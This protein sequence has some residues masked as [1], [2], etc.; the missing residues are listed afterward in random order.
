MSGGLWGLIFGSEAAKAGGGVS[1][2]MLGSAAFF[3]QWTRTTTLRLHRLANNSLDCGY[4]KPIVEKDRIQRAKWCNP[5]SVLD[6]SVWISH[7]AQREALL[8][9]KGPRTLCSWRKRACISCLTSQGLEPFV[10]DPAMDTVV[11][12]RAG[13]STRCILNRF[14]TEVVYTR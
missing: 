10:L 5:G 9:P 1:N 3:P 11:T 4:R 8:Q 13:C 7:R 2:T 6:Q 14:P 12:S